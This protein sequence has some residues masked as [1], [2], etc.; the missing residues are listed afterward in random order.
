VEVNYLDGSGSNIGTDFVQGSI[1]G[2]IHS[3][4]TGTISIR[5]RTV[6]YRANYSFGIVYPISLFAEGALP[7]V[8][9]SS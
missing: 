6:D 5:V 8:S 7:A 3:I 4:P 9:T 1:T 2:H